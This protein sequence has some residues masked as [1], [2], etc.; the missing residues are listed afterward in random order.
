MNTSSLVLEFEKNLIKLYL[1]S[2]TDKITNRFDSLGSINVCCAGVLSYGPRFYDTIELL[3]IKGEDLWIIY[4]DECDCDLPTLMSVL[5]E[6]S[7]KCYQ[8]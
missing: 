5:K 2:L 7:K 4:K 8:S 1:F 6:R 3:D